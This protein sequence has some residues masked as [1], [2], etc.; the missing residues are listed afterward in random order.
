[1]ADRI[2]CR[3][4]DWDGNELGFVVQTEH[5]SDDIDPTHPSWTHE[6]ECAEGEDPHSHDLHK[7]LHVWIE[8]QM[9][10]TQKKTLAKVKEIRTDKTAEM[11]PVRRR[12]YYLTTK[13]NNAGE[14]YVAQLDGV[15][16]DAVPTGLAPNCKLYRVKP[17]VHP[18]Q[19]DLTNPEHVEDITDSVAKMTVA[20]IELDRQIKNLQKAKAS[21]KK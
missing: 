2:F 6:Y 21:L 14:E 11:Q 10:P 7:K 1:M 12:T 13:I 9:T 5:S 19:A 15:K 17:W 4:K 16:D 20:E 18:K 8:D 3:T